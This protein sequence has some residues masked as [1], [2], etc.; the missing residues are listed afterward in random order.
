M[1][2]KGRAGPAREADVPGVGA[3]A[4]VEDVGVPAAARVDAL[5]IG[6]AESEMLVEF[7]YSV[8]LVDP[9]IYVTIA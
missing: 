1:G 8:K 3:A 7:Y 6:L 2:A 4:A 5:Y 9:V